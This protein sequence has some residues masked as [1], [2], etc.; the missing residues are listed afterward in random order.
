MNVG[1]AEEGAREGPLGANVGLDCLVGTAVTGLLVGEPGTT[2]LWLG[3]FVGREDGR[4][5]GRDVGRE[6][7]IAVGC[8]VGLAVG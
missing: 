4:D 8:A 3:R 1:G 6:V 5:V 7:G 2:G